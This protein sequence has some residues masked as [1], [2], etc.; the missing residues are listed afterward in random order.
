MPM[1][2]SVLNHVF[3]R[4]QFP[5]NTIISQLT[6]INVTSVNQY[7]IEAVYQFYAHRT[8]K[9]NARNSFIEKNID[10]IVYHFD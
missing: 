3:I 6:N 1:F 5:E 10:R 9:N 8:C 2:L 7:T 4:H